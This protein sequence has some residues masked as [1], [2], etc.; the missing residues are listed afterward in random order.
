MDTIKS[1]P[2]E[3]LSAVTEGREESQ[4]LGPILISRTITED[5][6]VAL[7]TR[8]C[9]QQTGPTSINYG[10][11]DLFQGTHQERNK[12]KELIRQL[13]TKIKEQEISISEL[14][15]A[16]ESFIKIQFVVM[17]LQ[18]NISKISKQ[19]VPQERFKVTVSK[20]D[21]KIVKP[22]TSSSEKSVGMTKHQ[23]SMG[24]AALS[25]YLSEQEFLLESQ[26]GLCGLHPGDKAY[27]N[28][29]EMFW[30]SCCKTINKLSS[31]ADNVKY[32]AP[33]KKS[34]CHNTRADT[35]NHS[36]KSEKTHAS[37]LHVWLHQ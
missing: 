28:F 15:S 36:T 17:K 12:D 11:G 5:I 24:N 25:Q 14:S 26:T 13:R 37:V 34:Q 22:F 33:D 3:Y 29:C 23:E 7:R 1:T 2:S 31:Q 10:E 16:V 21:P 20:I 6:P 30:N 32:C 4:Q 9:R 27:D 19:V 35:T 8:R 18:G